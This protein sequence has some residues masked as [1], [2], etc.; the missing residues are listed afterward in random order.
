[1]KKH[2]VSFSGGKDS[3]AM[4]LMMIEKKMPIDEILF[5]DSGCEFPDMIKHIDKVEKYINRKITTIYPD[6]DFE[7]Y[8]ARYKK[9][10]GKFQHIDGLGW[11]GHTFRWCTGN[12]KTKIIDRY[13]KN[14]GEYYSY[15]GIAFDERERLERKY[16]RQ[17]KAVLIYPMVDWEMTEK[18]ALRYCYGKGF[19]WNG[20]YKKFRR[21]SCYLC[22]LQR[23]GELKMLY[24]E[25]PELWN[26]MLRLDKLSY[27][28]FRVDSPNYTLEKLTERFKKEK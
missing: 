26:E 21:V 19:D 5:C 17:Q 25:F 6:H 12:L 9:K 18:D 8:L 16:H 24:N 23:I 1:M 27:R 4:L 28:A 3:T 15:L 2:I 11:P 13:L 20:L 14:K 22:P 7:Y 10:S